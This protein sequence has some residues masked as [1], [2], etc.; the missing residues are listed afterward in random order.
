MLR[1]ATIGFFDGV[2]CGHRCLITQVVAE[3]CRRGWAPL[4]VTFDRHPASVLHPEAAPPLLTTAD[5]RVAMLQSQAGSAGSVL[6]LPFTRE[7]AQLT[8]REFML[9]L[10]NEH[11]VRALVIGYD[12]RFGH[13]RLSRFE[14]YQRAGREVGVDVV[15][16]QALSEGAPGGAPTAERGSRCSS[17]SIRRLLL[18]GDVEAARGLLGYPYFLRGRVVGGFRIGRQLGYP[19]ANVLPDSPLKLIPRDGVYAVQVQTP[20]GPTRG[21]L[22]IGQRPT[23]GKGVRT[24]EAHLFHFHGDLYDATVEIRFLRFIREERTF[25]SPEQLIDQLRQDARTCEG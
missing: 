16:A 9:T 10:R 7:L 17:S 6:V 2:H 12:H 8:A 1:V 11:D 14:E 20:A 22:Y 19:T 23:F 3:A 21:M 4:L 13:D 24:I 15:Q 18:A 25:S 5:E